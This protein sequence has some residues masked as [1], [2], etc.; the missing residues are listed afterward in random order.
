MGNESPTEAHDQMP[1]TSRI[2]ALLF[3]SAGPVRLSQIAETLNV[4]PHLVDQALESMQSSYQ[5]RGLRLQ[6]HTDGVRLTT[7][8]ETAQDVERFLELEST[9]RL[10][11][12]ALE[13]LSI[14]AYQEPVTRPYIDSIRGVNSD[15]VIRTLLRY[16][17]IEEAGRSDSPGRPFLYRTTEEFL[18]Q[19]GLGSLEDLP[20]LGLDSDMESNASKKD[21]TGSNIEEQ[22]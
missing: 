7:A 22:A 3:V 6:R 4:T 20:P 13:V 21:E 15:S 14:V 2:E 12:A 9:V 19:F 5:Q 8:P 10:S 1:L 18:L 16:G 11:R 17:L